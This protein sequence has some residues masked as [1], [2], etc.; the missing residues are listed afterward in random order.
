[1]RQLDGRSRSRR[2][3]EAA[4]RMAPRVGVNQNRSRLAAD[5]AS[6]RS[7]S[8][9]FKPGV[10]EADIAEQVRRQLL[11]GIE[12]PALL[13]EADT[14]EIQR[15]DAAGLLGR[16]LAA[17]VGKGAAGSEAIGRAPDDLCPRSPRAPDRCASRRRRRRRWPR[18]RRKSCRH[19]RS[20]RARGRADRGCRRAWPATA[21]SA[22]AGARPA[23]RGRRGRR[24][25][26]TRAA[27]RCRRPRTRGSPPS[28]T[29]RR[30]SGTRQSAGP[31]GFVIA[32][33]QPTWPAARPTARVRSRS[34]RRGTARPGEADR[35]PASRSASASAAFRSRAAAAGRFPPRPR[36]GA[37]ALRSGSRGAAA[38][39][40]ARPRTERRGRRNPATP[41]D[42]QSSRCRVSSTS[43]T[44][45][46][47]RT[48]FL[49]AYSN[50]SAT[51]RPSFPPR[52]ASRFA[53]AGCAALRSRRHERLLRQHP[54][55][56][57]AAF[58]R[59]QRVLH[60]PILE[61]MKRDDGEPRAGAQPRARPPRE[62][63]RGR[64][65]RG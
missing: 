37:A 25:A 60:D 9:P 8:S 11:V 2:P 21:A 15:R 58:E 33:R 38:R 49:I 41:T 1:M 54:D 26:D 59:A 24:P 27:S 62:S 43:R 63:D 29:I 32:A 53:P 30:L 34:L 61:R 18:A 35:W 65:A 36:A 52:A 4:E 16:N 6:R 14:V 5:F 50:G 64:R 40:A 19:P 46:L 10:V 42:F 20:S 44:I 39:S 55:Q 23:P 13:D 51:V 31:G 3:L 22:P 56:R 7:H 12:T 28:H 57:L 47:F 48:S 45:G 17:D